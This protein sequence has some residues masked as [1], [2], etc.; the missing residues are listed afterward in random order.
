MVSKE[1]IASNIAIRCLQDCIFIFD[2]Q[3]H[4]HA[5]GYEVMLRDRPILSYCLISQMTCKKSQSVVRCRNGA[6][7][8]SVVDGAHFDALIVQML[9]WAERICQPQL[10]HRLP[11]HWRNDFD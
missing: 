1:K 9:D 4:R 6:A 3:E 2:S 7:T 10:V 11:Q 5:R 8:S